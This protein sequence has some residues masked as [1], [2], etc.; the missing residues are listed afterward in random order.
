[1]AKYEDLTG[2]K[3]GRLTVVG[4]G[5]DWIDKKNHKSRQWLCKCD[6][7]ST[8]ILLPEIRLKTGNTKSCGCIR[9]ELLAKRNK[10]TVSRNGES[11]T[12]IYRIW[13]AMR[14]RC[15]NKNDTHYS[16]YGGRGIKVCQEWKDNFSIFKEWALNNGYQDDLTIDRI[17][18]NGDYCPENCRWATY[19]QQANNTSKNKY[20]EYKGEIHT[21]SEWC[22]ILDLPY[23]RIK[24]RFNVCHMTPEEA[25]ELPKGTIVNKP[26]RRKI[27]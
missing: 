17:D 10:E 21:L 25:F 23:D 11:K 4:Q 14:H 8:G 20:I 18:S 2:K 19:E 1:M 6:C 26:K 22:K 12:R 15:Y 9:K 13:R 16:I 7:G 5:P 27:S 24:Q 3:F